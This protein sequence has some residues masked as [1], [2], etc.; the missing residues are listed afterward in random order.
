MSTPTR[1]HFLRSSA[2]VGAALL[3]RRPTA[4]VPRAGAAD[5]PN[6]RIRLAVMGVR[7][8]GRDLI[9]GFAQLPDVEIATLIDP[10]ENVVPRALKELAAVQK[11]EPKVEKDVRKALED[12]TINAL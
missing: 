5:R 11:T 3:A 6:E 9:H 8:R 10:D 7:G 2:A 4:W 1:R 12:P